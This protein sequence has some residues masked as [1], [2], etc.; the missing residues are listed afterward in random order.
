MPRRKRSDESGGDAVGGSE[1]AHRWRVLAWA[2]RYIYP[3]N[4]LKS[5]KSSFRVM[6]MNTGARAQR[7]LI[8][9][10]HTKNRLRISVVG[11]VFIWKSKI[12][13][14]SNLFL[15]LFRPSLE[16]F[17]PLFTLALAFFAA[18]ARLHVQISN[19]IIETFEG[20]EKEGEQ[21]REKKYGLTHFKLIHIH[22]RNAE[23]IKAP[24]PIC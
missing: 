11:I 7:E 9:E 4:V 24:C 2:G 22:L 23:N 17:H 20:R 5:F 6:E 8:W 19:S 16:L 1:R 18:P 3:R 13:Q 15:S 10:W 14:P 12:T 21:Q